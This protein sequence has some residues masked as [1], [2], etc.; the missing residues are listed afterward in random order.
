MEIRLKLQFKSTADK[1]L[2][3]RGLTDSFR[4]L[5]YIL[6]SLCLKYCPYLS[7]IINDQ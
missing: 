7:I 5:N 1:K 4:D 6:S 3:I 2:L